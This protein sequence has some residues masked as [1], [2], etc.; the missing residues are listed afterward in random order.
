MA[1]EQDARLTVQV[2][3][4]IC[5]TNASGMRYT[6]FNSGDCHNQKVDAYTI[7]FASSQS[8]A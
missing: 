4:I 1:S 6:A 5:N 7:I 2:P 3:R 8:R